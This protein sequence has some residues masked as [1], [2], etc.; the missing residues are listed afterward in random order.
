MITSFKWGSSSYLGHVKWT[1]EGFT[2]LGD[3]GLVM[4]GFRWM[5]HWWMPGHIIHPIQLGH[6][7]FQ[8]LVVGQVEI[9]FWFSEGCLKKGE[10]VW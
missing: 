1:Q 8:D 5:M 2:K 3:Q 4:M 10:E 6:K 9:F 7:K